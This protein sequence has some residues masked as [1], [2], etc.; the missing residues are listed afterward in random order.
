MMKQQAI[1]LEARDIGVEIEGNVILNGIS[2]SVFEKEIVALIG[3]NGAGKTTFLKAVLGLIPYT[4]R[5]SLFGGEK[6]FLPGEIGFVP[7]RFS[8]DRSFPITVREFLSLIN[9]RKGDEEVLKE[10][11]VH[12]IYDRMM[13][14]LSGG[15]MQRVLVAGVIASRPRLLLLDEAVS[16]ID[17][18]GAKNFYE[19]IKM[20]RDRYGM[21]VI[22]ISHEIN[23]VYNFADKVVCLNKDM[24]CF[25]N[26]ASALTP[27]TIEKLYGGE[28]SFEPR[29]PHHHYHGN[30]N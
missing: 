17:A 4:G 1:V 27:G 2:F 28:A 16:G 6:S 26:P 14:S 24:V 8:I 25:G 21:A 7:Q 15:E 13:G 12:R 9:K 10:L 20:A 23:I 18:E 11:G 29:Q 5:I 3:P 22:M 19:M 30:D